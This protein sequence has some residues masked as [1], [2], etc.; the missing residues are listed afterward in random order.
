[1]TGDTNVEERRATGRYPFRVP[2]QA[3]RSPWWS[4]QTEN[5]S[6]RGVLFTST[7]DLTVGQPVEYAVGPLPGTG[8]LLHCWGLVLRQHRQN[9]AKA[10]ALSI[11]RHKFVRLKTTRRKRWLR[12]KQPTPAIQ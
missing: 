6:S 4:G 5:L 9:G 7:V 1:M 3:A 12:S 2:I 11:R 8:V 10:F